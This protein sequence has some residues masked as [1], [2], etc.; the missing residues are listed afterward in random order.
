MQWNGRHRQDP[1]NAVYRHPGYQ[2]LESRPASFLNWPP[3]MMQTPEQS[4][5]D[6]IEEILKSVTV[7]F[8]DTGRHRQDPANAV[9]RH[10]GNQ[11]LR[12]RSASFLNRPPHTMQ[13]PAQSIEA[14]IYQRL[15]AAG[16]HDKERHRQDSANAV[17]RH[18][19]YQTLKS[20]LAS[21]KN[22][23][24]HIK[25]TP[26][27]LAEAGF[28]HTGHGDGVCCFACDGG[29]QHWQPEDDPW[30]EHCRLFPACPFARIQ[31]GDYF[32]ELIQ[33]SIKNQLET[34]TEN[35]M[36]LGLEELKQRD[37]ELQD[38]MDGRKA[39]C[40]EMGFLAKEIN[41]AI[42]ELR[43]KGTRNPSVEEI[44]DVMD[45]IKRRKMLQAVANGKL[46][47]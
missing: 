14:M 41:E 38:A 3:H 2:T 31:K 13:T 44:I 43:E 7:V 5:G 17:Y 1:E 16:F 39:V 40:K 24:P 4:E 45:V 12:S 23:P 6:M 35:G 42:N 26:L 9:C 8:C 47:H 27:Q 29:L 34:F 25:Q 22:W 28:Y 21:F 15:E 18:L 11:T 37:P 36:S 33:T 46:R 30:I 20:R 32:I 10:P 19:G